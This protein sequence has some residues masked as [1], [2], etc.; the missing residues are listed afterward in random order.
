MIRWL[1]SNGLAYQSADRN[2]IVF[3]NKE[4]DYCKIRGTYTFAEK[5]FHGCRKV[6]QDRF[7]Y[8]VPERSKPDKAY[9]T[10]A[11]I[12]A[13]SFFLLHSL[14]GKDISRSVY[15]SIGSASNHAYIDRIK[16]GITTIIVVDNDTAGNE[17]RKRHSEL[18]YAIPV[19][20][21]WN[22]DLRS[23]MA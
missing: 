23:R 18:D 7:W 8:F 13:I 10:E 15:I 5:T 6:R 9:V 3:V 22:D 21:D 4:R 2:N 20:K 14:D 12:D 19:L 11:T 1:V 17:C 16:T